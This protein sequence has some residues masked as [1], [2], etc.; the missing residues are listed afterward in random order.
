MVNSTLVTTIYVNPIIGD[1]NHR[2]SH[3][4]PYKSISQALATQK[5]PMMIQLAPGIYSI[6]S[7]ERF[8]LI[9]PQD[10]MITSFK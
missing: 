10:V 2:G 4:K 8:P 7:G 9:I 1:D 5:P 6:D 3:S